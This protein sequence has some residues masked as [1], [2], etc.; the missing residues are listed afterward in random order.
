[1]QTKHTPKANTMQKSGTK[2]N[3]GESE[4]SDT[5]MGRATQWASDDHIFGAIKWAH[6]QSAHVFMLGAKNTF[7]TV[8]PQQEKAGQRCKGNH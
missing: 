2:A 4:M 7:P 6:H 5:T 3:K 8:C 1:M